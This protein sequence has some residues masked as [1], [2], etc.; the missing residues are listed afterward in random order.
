MAARTKLEVNIDSLKLKYRGI[1][2]EIWAVDPSSGSVNSQ[3]AL[4]RINKEGMVRVEGLEIGSKK[5][6]PDLHERLRKLHLL[7]NEEEVEGPI[8]LVIEGI[9][10]Y[11]ASRG[12]DFKNKAVVN[13]HKSV[14]VVL[15]ARD[16]DEVIEVYPQSWHTYLKHK[17]L[18]DKYDKSDMNDA[19]VLGMLVAERLGMMEEQETVQ[20]ITQIC[21]TT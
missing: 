14:G 4:C 7:L 8:L 20:V 11:M 15:A 21:C 16:W 12:T 19:L 6:Q 2:P 18:F 5:H 1:W 13:L 9:P 10:P 17:D 3:P